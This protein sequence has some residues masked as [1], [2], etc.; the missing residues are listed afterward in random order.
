[1]DPLAVLPSLFGPI[2]SNHMGSKHLP[3]LS[4]STLENVKADCLGSSRHD[5]ARRILDIV[6]S[7]KQR[8]AYV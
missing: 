5:C 2:T 4:C 1:M 7:H 3:R 6:S 8:L